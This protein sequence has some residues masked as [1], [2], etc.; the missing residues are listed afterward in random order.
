ML[1][2]WFPI[3]IRFPP[4]HPRTAHNENQK[5]KAAQTLG[6][7]WRRS[8]KSRVNV[9]IIFIY[10]LQMNEW[11]LEREK[12]LSSRRDRRTSTAGRRQ[13]PRKIT[14]GSFVRGA[15]YRTARAVRSNGGCGG[16]CSAFLRRCARTTGKPDCWI[17]TTSVC[18]WRTTGKSYGTRVSAVRFDRRKFRSFHTK[19]PPPLP[20]PSP[21]HEEKLSL[22]TPPQSTKPPAREIIAFP[23]IAISHLPF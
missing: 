15:C 4:P 12:Q 16:G 3:C 14:R 18:A 6:N 11:T 13:S 22:T 10:S 2:K 21:G 7:R 19:F 1:T 8:C 5:R 17:T 20:P 23:Q 9:W